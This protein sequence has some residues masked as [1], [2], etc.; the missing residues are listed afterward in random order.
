MER[1]FLEFEAFTESL[2]T[3]L[4]LVYMCTRWDSSLNEEVANL[5]IGGTETY[6]PAFALTITTSTLALG[7]GFYKTL[8]LGP[9][10]AQTD[11]K[12]LV[13]LLFVS[14]ICAYL[15]KLTFTCIVLNHLQYISKDSLDSWL[16]FRDIV[17]PF[18]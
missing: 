15:S 18:L 4:I 1:E 8:A 14:V 12:V 7:V 3:L 6:D 13:I 5:I 9:C 16:I 17:L 10:R 11:S 2:P